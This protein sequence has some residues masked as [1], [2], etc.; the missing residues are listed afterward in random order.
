MFVGINGSGKTTTIAKITSLLQENNL[1][2]VMAAADTFRAAAIQ[3]LQEHA[4]RLGVKIVKH[5]YGADPAAV[6]FD[7]VRYAE[8]NNV[9][10]VLVDTAGRQH[11]NKNLME[12]I[13]K[14]VRVANPDL[15]I[16]IGES[17]TGN[18][19]VEQ[20]ENFNQAVGIDGIVLTKADVDEKG[21]AAI[22]ISHVTKKP[23]IYLGTG[24][25]YSDL[26]SFDPSIITSSLELSG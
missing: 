1:K 20:A 26:K 25:E 3:Q 16:F 21:G 15:K 7:A 23:I 10:V 14:I 22:S 9:D 6:A 24:Q 2:T 4:D 18:D 13:K 12:E 17:I 19:C 11:N 8:A 5:D